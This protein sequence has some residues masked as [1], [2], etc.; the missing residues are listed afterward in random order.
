MK[1]GYTPQMVIEGTK[2]GFW[3]ILTSKYR[4]WIREA[5]ARR[6]GFKVNGFVT[7]QVKRCKNVLYNEDGSVKGYDY[8]DNDWEIVDEDVPNLLTNGGRD[9]AHAQL[10]TNN[11]AGTAGANFLGV[12]ANAGAPAAGDTVLTGEVTGSGF[13]R[14]LC[15]TRTHT[16]GTNTTLLEHEFTATAQVLDLQKAGLFTAVT[17]GI[18]VHENTFTITDMENGDK[19]KISWTVTAG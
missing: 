13:V 16:A 14:I 2:P 17:G 3:R 9:W 19:L 5:Q 12:T 1:P 7:V 4:R 8:G 11:A 18:L 10:Y 6:R 15:P